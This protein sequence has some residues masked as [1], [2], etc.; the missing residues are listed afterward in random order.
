VTPA[1]WPAAEGYLPGETALPGTRAQDAKSLPLD[2]LWPRG[3]PRTLDPAI[4]HCRDWMQREA[5]AVWRRTWICAGLES[6]ARQPGQWFSFNLLGRSL[7]IIRSHDGVLRAFDNVCR[8]RG[9]PLLTGDFGQVAGKLVCGFHSW[10]YATSGQC[11]RVTDRGHFRPDA[12]AGSLDLSPVRV[13]CWAGFV[14]ITL[15]RAAPPLLDFLAPLLSLLGAYDFAG[16]HVVKDVVVDLHANWKLMLH[17]NLEAYHFHALHS[18]ALAYADDLVQ[19]IDFYPGG[20]SRFIT[21]TGIPSSRLPRRDTIFDEQGQLLA[22]AGIDPAGFMGGPYAVRGALIAA[23]RDPANPF[24][25]DY[26]PYSDSQ[27][28]DD[29]SISIFPNMSLNAHPE[30]VLFMRYLPHPDD[31]SR[32]DFHVTILM[33][34]LKPGA[35]PP[36]YMG[37]EPDADI[38]PA[39]R[40]PRLRRP[41]SAP[42]LGWALDSDC[43]MV[44]AQQRGMASPGMGPVRLSELEGRIVHAAAE[45]DRWMKGTPDM[46]VKDTADGPA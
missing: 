17:A 19:Q 12:L 40:P 10:A 11:S 27:A 42:G 25:L 7:I 15:D 46:Q 3:A 31:P 8:H 41:G 36:G 5:V 22:E 35:A 38:A 45:L 9:A 1:A 34:R 32:S 29:W 43:E 18:P 2:A 4:F 21:A 44:P 30:G 20:H 28:V 14:F 39:V 6:D 33:P 23:K 37:L 16:M 13:D 24:G 26:S